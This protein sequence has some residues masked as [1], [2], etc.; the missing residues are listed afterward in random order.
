M[1]IR[2]CPKCCD[3]IMPWTIWKAALRSSTPVICPNC[4]SV[5]S[6]PMGEYRGLGF[7]YV[8]AALALYQFFFWGDHSTD[9]RRL[10]LDVLWIAGMM[11]VVVIL[12]YL[13]VPLKLQSED[14]SGISKKKPK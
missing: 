13:N 11:T 4:K 9:A 6:K 10:L 14:S 8:A 5:V 2:R 12:F 3:R 7:I 1:F